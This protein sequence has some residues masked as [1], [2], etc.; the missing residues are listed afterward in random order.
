MVLLD[1]VAD[2]SYNYTMDYYTTLGVPKHASPD[3]I[4]Q[5]YRKLSSIHHPDK[6]G[7]KA[8]FQEINTAYQTLSDPQKRAEYDRPPQQNPFGGFNTF[9]AGGGMP[10]GMDD[11][12][13]QF[14]GGAGGPFG[15]HFGFTQQ[16]APQ[17][18]RDLRINMSLN[19]VDTLSEQTKAVTIGA[20]GGPQ[21]T[22][23]VT[24]PRGVANGDNI[25]YSGLGDK[26]NPTLPNGDLYVV[27]QVLP[28]P[29]FEVDGVDLHCTI[30]ISCFDAI[31]GI[32]RDIKT[33]DDKTFAI[34]IP[35]GTQS[36]T[37][38]RVKDQ[39][40]YSVHQAGR[41]NLIITVNITIPTVTNEEA[42]NS[43][44]K[45]NELTL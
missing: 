6:G 8:K 2:L 45:L 24:I 39:G 3:D 10:S 36:N 22:V 1:F 44:R 33:I 38:L 23:E 5:A 21:H 18:N 32:T 31:L 12:L 40:V 19:L 20:P 17:K 25:R 9:Q 35:P 41:G 13:H 43:I 29:I 42:L 4:K 28:H 7:D 37:K 15:A 16:R 34:T 30:S 11:V 27:Y 14:F 26:S